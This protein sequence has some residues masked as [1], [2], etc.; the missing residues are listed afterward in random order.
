[1][2][3][4]NGKTIVAILTKGRLTATE[5][6]TVVPT[7]DEQIVTPN[8]GYNALSS[9]TVKPVDSSIDSN[10]I[11]ENVKMGVEILGVTGTLEEQTEPILQ[12]KTVIPSTSQQNIIADDDYD[13]L[14]EVVIEAVE[15]TIDSNISPENIR[16]GVEILGVT[17]TLE[18]QTE[19]TLQI[20]T[21]TPSTSMQ[22][23]S[24]DSEYDGLSE[25]VV[26][27]VTASIDSDIKA[28]N[29]RSGVEILGVTGT[30]ES[31]SNPVE[32]STEA[33]MI[34]LATAE[35]ENK[36]YRFVGATTASY[37]QNEY[38][39]VSANAPD[40]APIASYPYYVIMY[41]SASSSKTGYRIVWLP[42][43]ILNTYGNNGSFGGGMSATIFYAGLYISG[44]RYQS[45]IYSTVDLAVSA[46]HNTNTSYTYTE[47]DAAYYYR[48]SGSSWPSIKITST[49]VYYSNFAGS[50]TYTS[51]N[52]TR[53]FSKNSIF[54]EEYVATRIYS[55]NLQ[56]KT[57][58]TNGTVT[59]DSG[60]AGLSSVTVNVPEIIPD[61]YI[62]PSGTVDITFNG[63]WDVSA[64][65]TA[66]VNVL[67]FPEDVGDEQMFADILT[68]AE[69]G[70]VSHVGQ[71]YKY[72][73]DTTDAYE[74]GA[75]YIFDY[76]AYGDFVFN[77]LIVDNVANGYTVTVY[78]SSGSDMVATIN[79]V[80]IA[81][82]ANHTF[83]NVTSL[84][85]T[86]YGDTYY[87][88]KMDSTTAAANNS[89][90]EGTE[91]TITIDHDCNVAVYATVF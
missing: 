59:P 42:Q 9:V 91:V 39:R 52:T 80:E 87:N 75:L 72:T 10:I 82:G 79:G 69:Q 74:S 48:S 62:K 19:P 8:E 78:N 6:R 57:A 34:A 46:I 26:E 47:S 27:A 65:D 81:A 11:P 51:S 63:V 36:V 54:G 64:A 58:T 86:S 66:N 29:I 3:E 28:T 67:S 38:Y 56:D 31:L 37:S 50:I 4:L 49:I 33:E 73:G 90:T 88:V 15:P 53:T 25:V 16:S 35:N 14:S 41:E 84:A 77:K 89:D 76:D 2:A 17:G 45:N 68:S 5:A 43:P 71:I 30:L 12:A 32:I 23:V 18:E 24:S 13:G 20:K 60:Y 21:I 55:P 40:T 1:M 61:G 7:T 83:I 70:D 85:F 44:P 22:T